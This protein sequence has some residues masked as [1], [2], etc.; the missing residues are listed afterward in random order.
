MSSDRR[1]L[2]LWPA[3]ALVIGHTIAVGIF[4]TPAELVGALASPALAA[5][6]WTVFG[7]LVLCG[8]LSFGELAARHPDV[9]GPYVYLREAWGERV[10]FLYGWQCLLVMDPG[11]TAALGAGLAEYLPVAWPAAGTHARLWSVVVIWILAAI[12]MSGIGVSG[13]FMSTLTAV[14]LAALGL[15]VG[16]AFSSRD[17]SWTHF[18]PFFER[19]PGAPPLGEALAL[20]SVA[21][22]FSFGGFWEAT[23]VAGE[24][25]DPQR[26]LPRALSIGVSVVAAAYLLTSLAFIYVVPPEGATS[27]AAFAARAGEALFGPSGGRVLSAIVVI[28]IVASMMGLILMAPRVYYAMS[29]DKLFPRS[30]ARLHPRRGVP[31]RATLVLAALSTIF[32]AIGTFQQ[33]VSFFICTAI[34]FVALAVGG[35]FVLRARDPRVDGFRTPGYPATPVFFIGLVAI[36]IALVLIARPLQALAGIALVLGGIPAHRLLMPASESE[37]LARTGRR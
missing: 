29:R 20:G 26:T 3:T 14:K 33:I 22:F 35:L 1:S 8:A 19:R 23:R 36:V 12:N 6:L 34:A 24:L 15:I 9:G 28:S 37:E 31:D 4:L 17:G 2:G 5:G 25:R 11:V 13:R 10:A 32:V 18:Q 16:L 21:A 27:A 30:I 7:I